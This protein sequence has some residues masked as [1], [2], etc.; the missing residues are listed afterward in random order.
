[1][2]N[3]ILNV[4]QFVVGKLQFGLRLETHVAHLGLVKLVFVV[5][6]VDFKLCVLR[7]LRDNFFV[8]FDNLKDFTA[9]LIYLRL[10]D[11]NVLPVAFG[12]GGH[13]SVVVGAQFV[14]SCLV[15][16][17]FLVLLGLQFLEPRRVL[18][19]VLRVLVTDVLNNLLL[20]VK[21]LPLFSSSRQNSLLE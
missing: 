11:L 8:L 2:L 4:S 13:L 1:M 14:E 15:G 5:N 9:F 18:Q 16:V 10:L 12:F 3:L 21:L 7:N 19:H 6:V 20:L 17:P